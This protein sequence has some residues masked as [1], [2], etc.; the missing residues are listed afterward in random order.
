MLEIYRDL[1]VSQGG[2]INKARSRSWQHMIRNLEITWAPV[3]IPKQSIDS[4]QL[5]RHVSW[6]SREAA[7]YAT[8]RVQQKGYIDDQLFSAK[9]ASKQVATS[10][11]ETSI[12]LQCLDPES[13]SSRTFVE[14]RRAF[15]KGGRR[16]RSFRRD[17]MKF[18][19][20][21]QFNAVADWADKYIAYSN[22]KKLWV[23]ILHIIMSFLAENWYF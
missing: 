21:L 11:E 4:K 5:S 8:A 22:L 3:S 2:T 23:N 6:Q 20:S 12:E 13:G 18:S 19:H 7:T 10:A 1:F 15:S 14:S 9:V 16:F 17:K